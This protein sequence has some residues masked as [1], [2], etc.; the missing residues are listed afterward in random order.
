MSPIDYDQERLIRSGISKRIV[1]LI[2][3]ILL[4][5]VFLASCLLLPKWILYTKAAFYA[6]IILYFRSVFSF[7]TFKKCI[8]GGKRYWVP[9]GITAGGVA[10][11]YVIT[12]ILDRTVFSGMEGDAISIWFNGPWETLLLLISTVFLAPV[13]EELFYRK[14]FID[15][16]SPQ[17]TFITAVAGMVLLAVQNTLSWVGVIEALI[18]A[19][20]LAVSYIKTR[21]IYVP[22]LVHFCLCFLQEAPSYIYIIARQL[23]K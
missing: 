12:R 2:P 4:E 13:A 3:P 1:Q 11:A 17:L 14:G 23:L 9:V 20:P 19:V 15:F 8:T 18:M 16:A 7:A 22:V 5:A 6:C 21:N 10:A